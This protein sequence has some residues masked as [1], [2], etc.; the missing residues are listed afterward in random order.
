MEKRLS[1]V[2]SVNISSIKDGSVVEIGDSFNVRL[3][4]KALAVQREQE[5]FLE[6]E[7]S[8]HY[9]IFYRHIPNPIITE[10]VFMAR[11]NECPKIEVNKVSIFG[12]STSTVFQIGSTNTIHSEARVKHIRHLIKDRDT[13]QEVE[14]NNNHS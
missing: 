8:F 9:P 5:L 6:N 12:V 1:I 3:Y 4:S 13:S 7:G 14:D 11:N 2:D 10:R